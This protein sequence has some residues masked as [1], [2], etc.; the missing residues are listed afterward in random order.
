MD[1]QACSPK[2]LFF[3]F[4][5]IMKGILLVNLGSPKDLDLKS[6]KNYLKEFLSDELVID[7]PELV[8]KFL[9][10]LIIVPIRSKNTME[11]YSEI[12][13]D[14][15]SPLINKSIAL[16]D[17]VSAKAKL[18]LEVAMRYQ[19]PSIKT[20]LLE[21]N[22]KGCEDVF[23]IP[24]YPHYAMSTTLTT[25]R[26]VSRINKE[27]NLKMK[28]TF[29]ESFYKEEEYINCLSELIKRNRQSDSDFLLFSYH[30]IPNRHLL[31]TDPT[32]SHCLK[33]KNCCSRKSEATPFCYKAQV[34]ETSRLCTDKLQLSKDEWGVSFQSRIGPGWIQ[35]FTDKELVR[36]AENGIKKLDVICPAFVTDNL[37]TLEEMN[38]RGRE[39][40]L[41]AGGESFN[42]I[43]CLNIED[44]WVDFLVNSLK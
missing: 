6:I 22:K 26:E 40:F 2:F 12:W 36:L 23:V 33:A 11:A 4:Q 9:V 34:L 31:K 25:Q 30:G 15:G 27:L 38:L 16:G 42:Y 1:F 24:L 13:T 19:E 8:R 28:L 20:G 37:E 17:K 21:L 18:P 44:A 41:D 10:N 35:P 43:P 5:D 14:K 7:Y 29:I 3:I 32:N 39:T